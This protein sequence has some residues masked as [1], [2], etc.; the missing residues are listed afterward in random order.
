MFKDLIDIHRHS[1]PHAA[2]KLFR[3]YYEF[4]KMISLPDFVRFKYIQSAIP[5][6]SGIKRNETSVAAPTVM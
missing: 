2:Y 5:F 6:M 3:V 4:R 1:K